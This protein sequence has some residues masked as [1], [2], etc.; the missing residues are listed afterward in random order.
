M[1]AAS[2][3]AEEVGNFSE[4]PSLS[5]IKYPTRDHAIIKNPCCCFASWCAC[6]MR[7]CRLSAFFVRHPPSGI[8]AA[9][10]GFCL[11]ELERPLERVR[12]EIGDSG[13]FPAVPL[14][15]ASQAAMLLVSSYC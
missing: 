6:R 13:A 14:E 9:P 1:F 15:T 10:R 12:M 7:N 8:E 11:V 2:A 3:K 4:R 5:N